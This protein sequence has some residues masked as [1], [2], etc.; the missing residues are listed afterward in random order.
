MKIIECLLNREIFNDDCTLGRFYIEGE[1]YAYTCE[2]KE[3]YLEVNGPDAKVPKE[4]AIPRG[5]YR[6]TVTYS[7]RFNKVMPELKGV[8]YF[9]GVRIHGGN[10][11]DDTEGCPLIGEERTENGVRKCKEVVDGLIRKII[12]E[13][14][15]GNLFCVTVR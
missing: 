2:D 4:T 9:T 11:K 6:M 12:A 10:T 14:K 7:K 3:R 15:L 13:E 5:R 1:H 8:P